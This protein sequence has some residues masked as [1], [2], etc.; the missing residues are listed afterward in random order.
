[1]TITAS[2]AEPGQ[3]GDL[4]PRAGVMQVREKI[5]STGSR[6]VVVEFDAGG[7]DPAEI[8]EAFERM[9]AAWPDA[10]VP[11]KTGAAKGTLCGCGADHGGWTCSHCTTHPG[12]S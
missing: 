10:R 4:M 7:Q 8:Y 9:L 1:M 12:A 6:P 2:D 5:P 11:L 3:P